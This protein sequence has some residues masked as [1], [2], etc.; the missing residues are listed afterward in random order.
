MPAVNYGIE[1][2]LYVDFILCFAKLPPSSSCHKAHMYLANVAEECVFYK[3]GNEE[4]N[5][6]AK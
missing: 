2:I 3:Y 4:K 1:R 6:F 5:L